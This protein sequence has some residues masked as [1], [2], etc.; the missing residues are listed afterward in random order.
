MY[1]SIIIKFGVKNVDATKF[2]SSEYKVSNVIFLKFI[3]SNVQDCNI[4][5]NKFLELR[6]TKFMIG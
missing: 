5:S 3:C 6:G 2:W 4:F 1:L